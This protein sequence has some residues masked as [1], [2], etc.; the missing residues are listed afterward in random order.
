MISS[1]LIHFGSSILQLFSAWACL[2]F[3]LKKRIGRVWTFL[4]VVFLAKGCV[5]AYMGLLKYE[6]PPVYWS[7]IPILF[8][9]FFVSGLFAMGCCFAVKW[10]G[11]KERL[12]ARSG[13][14]YLVDHSFVGELEEK[15]ILEQVCEVLTGPGGYR[16]AW[17]GEPD[18]DGSIRV[19]FAAGADSGAISG[20]P[21]RWD[22]SPWGHFPPGVAMGSGET[23]VIRGR[24]KKPWNSVPGKVLRI[25][26][27]RSC[28]TVP[29]DLS[30]PRRTILTAHSDDPYAFCAAET[31]AFTLMVRRVKD[32]IH[33]VRKREDFADV[34]SYCDDMLR[35]QPDGILLIREK[36]VIWANPAAAE[37]LAYY[38]SQTLLEVDLSSI[39][40]E[41][42]A[43]EKFK[44]ALCGFRHEGEGS[45]SR[46]ETTV[47]RRDK[48]SFFGEIT[49]TCI[50]LEGRNGYISTERGFLGMVTL[51]DV[52]SSERIISD[53]RR[54]LYFSS[55]VQELSFA[56]VMELG[57]EGDIRLFNR[58]CEEIS[59]WPSRDA[60]GKT[61]TSFL[62]AEPFR[63][64]HKDMFQAVLSERPLAPLESRIST[65]W[66]DERTV[67]WKYAPIYD[68]L[69][70]ISSVIVAG[71]DVTDRRRLEKTI[72]EMQKME[73]VGRLAGGIAHDFNNILTGILGS[74]DIAMKNVSAD[75]CCLAAKRPITDAI[76]VSER[77]VTLIRQLLDFSR[78][79]PQVRRPVNIGNVIKEV[80]DLFSQTI[81]R[82]IEISSFV[83]EDLPP[84]FADTNQVH[85]V[86][87]NL[88]VNARDA[89]MESLET[90]DGDVGRPL[91]GHWIYV[92]AEKVLVDDDYCRLVPYARTGRFIR[93]SIDDNGAGMDEALQRRVFEP[94]F[95]TKKMG[96]GTGLGLSTVY[97]IVKQHNGWINIDSHVG[98]GTTFSAYFPEAEDVVEEM[99]PWEEVVQPMGKKEIILFA[100]D[101]KLIRDLGRIVLESCGYTVLTASDG[102]E[103]VEVYAKNK[104]RVHLVVLDITMPKRSGLEAMREIRAENPQARFILSSGYTPVEDIG[105]AAFLP[106]PYRADGLVRMVRAALDTKGST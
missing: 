60:V 16:L 68:A 35:D 34:K 99:L 64:A 2:F 66:G 80:V 31:A 85:Q 97:G 55:K 44:R 9:E 3:I 33:A 57:L 105:D 94:F 32:A 52:T 40:A 90:K 13:V 54:E 38:D 92:R 42:D 58:Q 63:E 4:F 30:S 48:T 70:N 83:E 79:S 93:I 18:S 86:L 100:D 82:R 50:S 6:T 29:I 98:K 21:F 104:D 45:H 65:V 10:F 74:L 61:M 1:S 91:T 96:R 102:E 7:D 101:E 11:L 76:R 56:M 8:I 51:R 67:S 25:A 69:G 95:T 46:W 17:A 36:K 84:A 81:D 75:D 47:Q 23:Q 49:V 19:L 26:G 53:L 106:K 15:R 59:G 14:I 89:I 88:C 28:I 77:A 27:L 41:E 20:F 43:P 72:I 71:I 24:L 22:D 37:M 103:A 78:R 73:A 39:L 5:S 87:M 62:I 12:G